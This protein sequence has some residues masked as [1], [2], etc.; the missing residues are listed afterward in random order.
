MCCGQKR[1]AQRNSA[2]P[3]GPAVPPGIGV[4]GM[5]NGPAGVSFVR[6]AAPPQALSTPVSLRYLRNSPIRVRGAATGR[7]YD[8]SASRQTQPVDRRDLPGLL[9]TGFFRQA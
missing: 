4:A 5:V 8:F 9:R 3:S 2:T 1:Q 6:V 7:S